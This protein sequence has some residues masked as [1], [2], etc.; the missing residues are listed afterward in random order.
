MQRTNRIFFKNII[1]EKPLVPIG[2][3]PVYFQQKRKFRFPGC[4]YFINRKENM[5]IFI[6][7]VQYDLK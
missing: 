2:V 5:V 3:G 4:E 7:H 6:R 1:L